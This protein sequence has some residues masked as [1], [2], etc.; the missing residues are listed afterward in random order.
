MKENEDK[1][2]SGECKL[3]GCP[4]EVECDH[5][6]S[7]LEKYCEYHPDAPECKIFDL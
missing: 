7:S 6:V 1:K 5:K 4:V 2:Y 3:C